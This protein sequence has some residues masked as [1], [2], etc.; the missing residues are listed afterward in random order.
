[1]QRGGG[2]EKLTKGWMGVRTKGG[3]E[4]GYEGDIEGGTGGDVRRK[5]VSEGASERGE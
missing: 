1:M 2:G 4:G 3:R 5:G